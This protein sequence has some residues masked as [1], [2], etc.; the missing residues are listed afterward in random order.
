MKFY[1]ASS[2]KNIDSVKYVS[3][4]LISKGFIHTYDW[5]Q[6]GK[7]STIEQLR[8]IGHKEKNAVIEADF[9]VVLLPAGKGSH[10]ELGIALG[11]GKP[12]YLHSPN[13]EVTNLE[14]TSTFYHLPEVEPCFG[15]IEELVDLIASR[16]QIEAN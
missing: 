3:E 9:I 4:R 6:L 7:A 2:F 8:E 16:G 11:Q 10:I 12:I 5:T 15:T 13:E 1:V 14:T